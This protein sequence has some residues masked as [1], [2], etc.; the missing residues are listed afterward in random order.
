MIKLICIHK[1]MKLCEITHRYFSC[2]EKHWFSVCQS[3]QKFVCSRI[4]VKNVIHIREPMNWNSEIVLNGK[5][6]VFS[7]KIYQRNDVH[8]L[9]H[10]FNQFQLL[11]LESGS[12]FF[13]LWIDPPYKIYINIHI[14]TVT[15]Q[16]QFTRGEEKLAFLEMGPYCFQ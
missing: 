13:Y 11:S 12:L 15:N 7:S 3:F 2:F 14:F 1:R 16:E 10:K 9:Y 5:Y 8:E 4:E 6:K